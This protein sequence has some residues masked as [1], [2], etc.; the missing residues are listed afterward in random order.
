MTPS[1][2]IRALQD[3]A[4]AEAA[5]TRGTLRGING[6]TAPVSTGNPHY[7]R[8][9]RNGRYRIERKNGGAEFAAIAAIAVM[10]V[11]TVVMAVIGAGV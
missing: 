7:H 3:A 4:L 10:V 8:R 6:R 5:A 9:Y 1:N 2:D 11:V